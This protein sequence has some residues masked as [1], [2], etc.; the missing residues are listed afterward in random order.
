MVFVVSY[1]LCLPHVQYF[2]LSHSLQD[3]TLLLSENPSPTPSLDWPG[4]L[5]LF[6]VCKLLVL[7]KHR[8][9]LIVYVVFNYIISLLCLWQVDRL[10]LIS[11]LIVRYVTLFIFLIFAFTVITLHTTSFVCSYSFWS[12]FLSS[13]LFGCICITFHKSCSCFDPAI[14]GLLIWVTHSIVVFCVHRNE[15]YFELY[16]FSFSLFLNLL[17]FPGVLPIFG[18][19]CL[20][21][22]L[23]VCALS[24]FF[25][26][27]WSIITIFISLSRCI[28]YILCVYN[29]WS[30]H[31]GWWYLPTK[32]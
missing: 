4:I 14:S 5:S 16:L 28:T 23:C 27:R 10:C 26:L 8:H 19:I 32:R 30:I 3:E 15:F 11:P 12:L 17:V 31:F 6:I 18:C 13:S 25:S 7:S 9:T 20:S 22:R 24:L 1:D 29:C 2:S 21:M